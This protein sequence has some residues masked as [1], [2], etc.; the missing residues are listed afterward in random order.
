M[1]MWLPDGHGLSPETLAVVAE[2]DLRVHLRLTS[3]D[4]KRAR[5]ACDGGLGELW[6]G[7]GSEVT[8][9]ACLEVVHA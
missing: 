2:H 5:G 9:P 6:T 1:S 3:W 4:R 8:C 7:V